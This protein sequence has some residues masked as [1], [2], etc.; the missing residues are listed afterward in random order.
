VVVVMVMVLLML[1]VMVVVVVVV[2]GTL[3][4]SQGI[5]AASLF[6]SI[7]SRFAVRS[8]FRAVLNSENSLPSKRCRQRRQ[9]GTQDLKW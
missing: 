1:M 2:D 3:S 9:F 5:A 6:A 4:R 8:A 7:R